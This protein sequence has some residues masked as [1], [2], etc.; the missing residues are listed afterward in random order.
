MTLSLP[1]PL[2]ELARGI[3]SFYERVGVARGIDKDVNSTMTAVCTGASLIFQAEANPLGFQTGMASCRIVDPNNHKR[4]IRIYAKNSM[5]LYPKSYTGPITLAGRHT[6]N[7]WDS[8]VI[9]LTARQFGF[10]GTYYLGAESYLSDLVTEPLL[11][12][13]MKPFDRWFALEHDLPDFRDWR[14]SGRDWKSIKPWGVDKQIA[15][16]QKLHE[17]SS[18]K[19]G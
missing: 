11:E 12:N 7:T 17:L 15:V 2:D 13:G 10:E 14:A 16:K 5:A 9:D 3:C 6:W 19:V 8:L 18:I 1:A 4:K